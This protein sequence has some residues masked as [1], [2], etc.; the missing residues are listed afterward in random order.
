M[1][2]RAGSPLHQDL[3]RVEN[4]ASTK[5]TLSHTVPTT[6]GN[7]AEQQVKWPWWGSS[8]PLSG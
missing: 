6:S 3:G 8:L 1:L 4:R 2:A 5:T 7:C